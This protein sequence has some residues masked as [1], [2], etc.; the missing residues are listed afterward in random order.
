[1]TSR[2]CATGLLASRLVSDNSS[3]RQV[4][5]LDAVL[6]LLSTKGI[7]GVSMR[8]VAREAGVS[9]GLV[10]YHYVDK[11]G[12]IAA[13]LRRIEDD[14]LAIVAPDPSLPAVDQL[15]VALGKVAK[16]EFLTAHYLA[17]RLQLWALAT[18]NEEF[19]RINAEA[20]ERYRQGLVALI[21]GA[22]PHLSQAE[23]A[24]RAADIDV[25]Q[26]WIWLSALIGI[27]H[28]AVDRAV[29]QC[30]SIALRD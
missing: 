22:R 4:R 30:E 14:D 21:A 2:S 11:V 26:N 17:L 13:A 16:P 23:C 20:Q 9:L 24:N 12:L 28:R 5:I 25:I 7:S 10:N 27:D 18:A 3:D 6:E 19:A 1:M 15:K 8:A 29:R